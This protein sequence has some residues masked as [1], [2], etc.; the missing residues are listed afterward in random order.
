[1]SPLAPPDREGGNPRITKIEDLPCKR[2]LAEKQTI[3]VL[4]I[5]QD[6][7]YGGLV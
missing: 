3:L 7:G 1:L 2:W 6:E 4:K 5:Q